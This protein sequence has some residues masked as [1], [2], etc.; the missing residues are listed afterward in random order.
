MTNGSA[1]DHERELREVLSKL[2]KTSEKKT[3]MFKKQLTWLGYHKNQNGVKPIKD[4]T[5][6]L[7]KLAAPKSVKESKSFL[8]SI[9]Y[10][11]KFVN[12]LSKKTV[13]MRKL[14]QKDSKWVSTSEINDDFEKF[15]KEN[16]EA[17]CCAFRPI[18]GQQICNTG[19]GATLWQKEGEVFRPNAF[20][21][22]C[23]TDCEEICN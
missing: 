16:T 10:Q 7:A 22:R 4:K 3:E 8:G 12:Y 19:L 5:E 21:S 6:A 9:Q 15:K 14:F 18:E 20:A 2:E 11:Y 1:D 23:I 13:R 17:P